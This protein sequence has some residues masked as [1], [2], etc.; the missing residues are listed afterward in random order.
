[1]VTWLWKD[2]N[3]DLPENYQLSNTEK[4]NGYI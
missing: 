1:M 3:P 2:E 4:P